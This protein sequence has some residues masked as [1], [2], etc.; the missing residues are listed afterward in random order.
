MARHRYH[1]NRETLQ[2]ERKVEPLSKR[3]GRLLV[4][5]LV[6]GA[7]GLGLLL[8]YSLFFETPKTRLLARSGEELRIQLNQLQEQVN[9]ASLQ[10]SILEQR[11]NNVYRTIF[12][13][14]SI[15]S[16]I[17]EGGVGGADRYAQYDKLRN[18]IELTELAKS[19]DNLSWRTYI[20]SKSFDEV[21]QMAYEKD[22]LMHCIPAVQPVSVKQLT[23]MSSLFGYRQ[24]PFTKQPRMHSGVDFVGA[25]GTPIHSTGDGVVIVAV[26]SSTGYGNQVIVDHGFG[27]KTRYAHLHSLA[28]SEGDRIK[29][30]QI[31]GAMGNSGRSTATHLHYEVLIRNHPV[32]PLHY[33]NDMSEDEYEQML[34]Q[35]ILQDLD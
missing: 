29:R 19:I 13:S 18:G 34:S 16:S 5:F 27:Y 26:R 9:S 3:L 12:E 24:D 25:Q 4:G 17:R 1:F 10:L 20:Q 6:S 8:V 11:D 30:G 31:V 23:R 22:R 14:D 2:Y 28:V 33:F 7:L 15:P 32:N 35:A 21:L